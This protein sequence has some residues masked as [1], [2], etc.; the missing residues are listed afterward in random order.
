MCDMCDQTA[1]RQFLLLTAGVLAAGCQ[2]NNG[3]GP[4]AVSSQANLAQD[5]TDLDADDF[6]P[7]GEISGKGPR[8]KF[9]YGPLVL[10]Q[11]WTKTNPRAGEGLNWFDG[12]P[13]S[14]D[15]TK[16]AVTPNRIT[17]HHDAMH[18][19][20]GH[21]FAKSV[22]RLRTI[23]KGHVGR[24]WND[25]G[26]HFAIDGR[27]RIWQCRPLQFQ[28]AHVKGENPRNLGILM[29]GNF[30]EQK[31]TRNQVKALDDALTKFC[32]FYKVPGRRI[33]GHRELGQTACPG[34]NLFPE[35]QRI[36]NGIQVQPSRK[37][38]P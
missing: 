24:G 34:K 35:V 13:S 36:R 22:D 1:R 3:R 30:E 14:K 26:Y 18:W 23:R 37:K 2:Y 20:G 33:Y 17:V 11:T 25:I 9:L 27:G 28:G 7:S 10:R 8:A 29:M 15:R 5:A 16:S 19:E 21:N 31:P 38:I 32:A 6:K 12:S 4:V